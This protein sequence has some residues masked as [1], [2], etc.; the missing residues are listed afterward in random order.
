MGTAYLRRVGLLANIRPRRTGQTDPFRS[1]SG[2]D[3]L[4]N[5]GCQPPEWLCYC[6]RI[7]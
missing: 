1:F 6:R 7:G 4:V 5:F 3:T 2:L